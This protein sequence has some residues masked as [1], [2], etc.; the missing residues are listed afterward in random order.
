MAQ[1]EL[2]MTGEAAG[3]LGV[4]TR[5]V[6][7]WANDGTLPPVVQGNGVTGAFVFRAADVY[8]LA[9]RRRPGAA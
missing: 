5:Q 1:P 3:I 7:R 8:D 2:V 6:A 4:S 9:E